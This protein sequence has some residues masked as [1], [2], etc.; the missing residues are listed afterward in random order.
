MLATDTGTMKR[1]LA[2]DFDP[3]A[4][5]GKGVRCMPMPKNGTNGHQLTAVLPVTEPYDFLCV[6]A[7]SRPTVMNTDAVPIELK[8]GKG[9]PLVMAVVGDDLIRL[10]PV[11]QGMKT[12]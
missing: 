9:L 1:C 10:I 12:E 8:S 3:Q 2:A 6:Q 7:M 11:P 5:G 4:R